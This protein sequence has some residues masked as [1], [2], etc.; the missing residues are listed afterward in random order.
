MN[1]PIK[2]T[3]TLR[4]LGVKKDFKLCDC[5]ML[6]GYCKEMVFG[7]SENFELLGEVTADSISKELD[8]FIRVDLCLDFDGFLSLLQSKEIYFVNPIEKPKGEDYYYDSQVSFDEQEMLW[9]GQS[10]NDDL[11]KWQEAKSKLVKKVVIIKKV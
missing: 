2:L 4:G 5:Y 7:L 9:D 8:D 3:D 10:Y 6:C 1:N 11:A